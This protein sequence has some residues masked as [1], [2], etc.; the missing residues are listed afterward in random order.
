MIR[1]AATGAARDQIE[2]H[3]RQGLEMIQEC[4]QIPKEVGHI[5]YQHHES[6]DRSGLP[7]GLGRS[8]IYAPAMLVAV[9][10]AWSALLSQV[11]GRRALSPEQAMAALHDER[12]SGKHDAEA[13]QLMRR[14]FGIATDAK[15]A[16]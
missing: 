1:S 14:V 8:S 13:L 15:R 11:P 6:P 2:A 12:L 5:V 9:V 16:A 4:G 10:D 3:V 7:N